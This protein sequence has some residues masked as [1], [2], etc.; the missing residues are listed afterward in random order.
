MSDEKEKALL[1]DL[2]FTI[3]CGAGTMLKPGS[4]CQRNATHVLTLTCTPDCRWER[5]PLPVC[6]AHFIHW[7]DGNIVCRGHAG[8]LGKEI[9]LTK[10][11]STL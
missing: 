7:S 2:D 8:P 10:S 4:N 9:L 5:M 1:E 11:W 3:V 6:S